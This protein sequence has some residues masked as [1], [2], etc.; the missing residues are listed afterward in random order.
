M[1]AFVTWCLN[2]SSVIILSTIII[3]LAGSLGATQLRQ[4]LFPDIEF[5]FVVV[6]VPVEGLSATSVDERVSEPLAKAARSVEGAQGVTSVSQGGASRLYVQLDFG[7]DL[8]TS[9]SNILDKLRSVDLPDGAGEIKVEGGF[10]DQA[11]LVATLRA[12]N[13]QDLSKLATRAEQLKK[14]LEDIDGV[15]KVVLAGGVGRQY[16]VTLAQSAIAAG[17]SPA[18]VAAVING[19]QSTSPAGAVAVQG[20]DLP[21]VVR[22]SGVK[23]ANALKALRLPTGQQ[24]GDVAKI[25]ESAD[26]TQ[27]LSRTNGKP[28]ISVSVYRQPSANEVDV[29]EAAKRKLN[30]VRSDIGSKNVI[31]VTDTS[32]DIKKSI[33]GLLTESALGAFFAV[34]VIFLFLRSVRSTLIAAISIPTSVVF[35]LVV[36]WIM[37]LSL[38]I[39]TLAGLTIAI[40]RVIDD[41][42][43]VIENINK[44][45]ERG[46][47][48]RKAVL[49]GT[50]E[51]ATAIASSTVATAAV[52]LPIGLVG[53]FVS[54][55]FYSFSIIV[56]VALV[57]SLLVATTVIPVLA[58]LLLSPSSE[59]AAGDGVLERMVTPAT[60]FGVRHRWFVIIAAVITFVATLG[61][62][63]SGAVPTQF[64]PDSGVQQVYGSVNLP[65][66]TTTEQAKTALKPLESWVNSRSDIQDT[67]IAY[68]AATLLLDLSQTPSTATFFLKLKESA[69]PDKVVR[70]L[71][72]KGTAKYPG[73]FKV[74]QLENGPPAGNFQVAVHG[75][76]QAS[77]AAASDAI[78]AMLKD[79][80]DLVE[81]AGDAARTQ[82]ELSVDMR[83]G[84]AV[85]PSAVQGTIAALSIKAP[86]GAAENGTSIVVQ[87]DP[88]LVGSP[89]ALQQLP[90]LGGAPTGAGPAPNAG[91]S[92]GVPQASGQRLG[93]VAQFTRTASP[94]IFV[95]TDGELSANVT[96]K[97]V[98][99]N[100][101]KI[102]KDVKQDIERL[103]QQGKLGDATVDYSQGDAQFI[104]DMFRDLGIAMLTAIVLVYLVLVLFFGSVLQPLTILA[105]VLFSTIGSLMAL[106][107]SG[108]ALGLPAMIGQLL[109]I[110]IVVSN[111]ILL[112]DTA[113][114]LRRAGEDRTTALV[115][116]ARLRV[117]PVLMTALATIAALLPLALGI[118]GEGGIIGKSLGTVVVGGLLVATLLT[119]V[120]VPAVF[121]LFNR[122]RRT[123]VSP[124][125]SSTPPATPPVA[126]V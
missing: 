50:S 82:P 78:V 126:E 73:A 6:T 41:G 35:G 55:I 17:L 49:D 121:T 48:R 125:T 103:K 95:R 67:Q 94:S 91:A 99:E 90:L 56:S 38:D 2:R 47:R 68:G 87:T 39:I 83:P 61:V 33:R 21:L 51:V 59:P 45:L 88:S 8:A 46:E 64:L 15:G 75:P 69:D 89:Q 118:S 109:L 32:L 84:T 13:E 26:P 97:L 81:I 108:N 63:G 79:R 4:Q 105:P 86:A 29:V 7:T 60:R 111:S 9:R 117:R 20:V 36:A 96:G 52:F 77:I 85:P 76:N 107:V 98:G 14:D 122:E 22:G 101:G 25:T 93:D 5:P 74:Q 106:V 124:P 1:R 119:L 80:K 58:G 72:A 44:H 110:G 42:I 54:E 37:G 28:S 10:S 116:A 12:T 3:V 34:V 120:I 112:V 31:V 65:P 102:L 27:G 114:R 123:L 16:Q 19:A 113:L 11:S 23:N 62:V 71:R 100:T 53:G 18:T 43:V 104:N 24:L 115:D 57:A 40:G 70:E 66:G 30:D 92:T